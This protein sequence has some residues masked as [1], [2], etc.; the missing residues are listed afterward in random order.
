MKNIV[1]I[2]DEIE[3]IDL[4]EN[5]F[6]RFNNIK[7]NKF[8]DSQRGLSFIKSHN[9]DLVVTDITMPKLD[10]IELLREIKDFKPNLHVIMMTAEASLE[11]VLKSH[12][13]DAYDFVTKPINLR[14]FE[15]KVKKIGFIKN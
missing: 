12:R 7:I 9:I 10:G 1:L 8:N 14:E 5:F 11:R 15:N 3:M 6:K 13:Y 4:M 2:D